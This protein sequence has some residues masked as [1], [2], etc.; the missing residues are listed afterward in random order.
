[1]DQQLISL[2]FGFFFYFFKKGRV[3]TGWLL[4]RTSG[5]QF[6]E[7]WFNECR[8][9]GYGCRP[10]KERSV[11]DDA[12]D[13]IKDRKRSLKRSDGVGSDVHIVSFD[14]ATKE[15]KAPWEIGSNCESKLV[16]KENEL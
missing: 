13:T 14:A 6:S 8:F 1:M 3:N 11:E 5:S 16:D 7:E 12:S 2:F 9:I 4:A 10:L 15:S